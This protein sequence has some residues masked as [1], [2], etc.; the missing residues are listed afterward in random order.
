VVTARVG[1]E[2]QRLVLRPLRGGELVFDAPR[3]ALGYY[4]TSLYRLRIGSRLGGATEED[5]RRLG[6][7]VVIELPPPA[8][9]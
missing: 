7:F 5:P 9:P 6:S 4:G 2:R 8:T 3:A 1:G